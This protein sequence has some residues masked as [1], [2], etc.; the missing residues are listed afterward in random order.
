MCVIPT[1]ESSPG[2]VLR[3]SWVQVPEKI[4]SMSGK[5]PSKPNAQYDERVLKD[6]GMEDLDQVCFLLFLIK[7]IG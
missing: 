3:H 5:Y 6:P 1:L 7:I 4:T 2:P